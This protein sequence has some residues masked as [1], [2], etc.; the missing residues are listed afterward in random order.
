MRMRPLSSDKRDHT[1]HPQILKSPH[2]AVGW[3]ARP[4]PACSRSL[5]ASARL[6][7]SHHVRASLGQSRAREL[8]RV[9]RTPGHDPPARAAVAE[10]R[11]QAGQAAV[12]VPDPPPHEPTDVLQASFREP[13]GCWSTDAAGSHRPADAGAADGDARRPPSAPS[14]SSLSRE[15]LLLS[16]RAPHDSL[17]LALREL[18]ARRDDPRR[19]ARRAR[20]RADDTRD[21]SVGGAASVA[22]RAAPR[23]RVEHLDRRLTARLSA[24]Q[25][26]QLFPAVLRRA[27]RE[28]ALQLP[29]ARRDR[30][31][32]VRAA[33]RRVRGAPRQRRRH[34]RSLQRAQRPAGA[35]AVDARARRARGAAARRDGGR[36][37]LVVLHACPNR[38]L[39]SSTPRTAP[40]FS[41]ASRRATP[42]A[43]RRRCARSCAS[44][45]PR[46]SR[47]RPTAARRA[48]SGRRTRGS[49]STAISASTL[50]CTRPCSAPSVARTD[51]SLFVPLVHPHADR[52]EADLVRGKARDR[53]GSAVQER[54][55]RACIEWAA[56]A[57]TRAPRGSSRAARPP[58]RRDRRRRGRRGR[59]GGA[60]AAAAG[61]DA[62]ASAP[63][64]GAEGPRRPRRAASAWAA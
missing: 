9:A 50:C 18:E 36:R 44:C 15:L 11:G 17:P 42:R 51:P 5:F 3:L 57:R 52:A 13:R 64:A 22:A 29:R 4:T 32:A 31:A 28:H 56:D 35:R 60:A 55:E 19:R 39:K 14:A 63:V 62:G 1:A 47:S 33:R 30:A 23:A 53:H 41:R 2:S 24:E 25:R 43:S 49:T 61:S 20:P 37:A 54:L 45:G 10:A 8:E 16:S 7:S 59:R 58:P 6:R 27:A 48:R 46:R 12:H 21:A 34:G 26:A 40:R 38:R